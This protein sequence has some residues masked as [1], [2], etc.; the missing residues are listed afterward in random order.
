MSL[1]TATEDKTEK[2]KDRHP[3]V[4]PNK[5]TNRQIQ[6]TLWEALSVQTLLPSL[7]TLPGHRE[8]HLALSK[9]TSLSNT[10]ITIAIAINIDIAI[11]IKIGT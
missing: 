7:A 5:Q 8:A 2:Y 10:A 6:I 4:Q 11:N 1:P 3:D 9:G